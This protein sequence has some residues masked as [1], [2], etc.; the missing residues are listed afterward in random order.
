MPGFISSFSNGEDTVYAANADFT[1]LTNQNPTIANGLQTNGQMW[2][3][4]TALNVGGTHINVGEITSPSGT[5]SIGYSAPNITIDL[6]GGGVGIDSIGV[7]T[8]TSPVVPDGTGLITFNGG[9]V[10]S[11]TNPVRTNGTGANTVTLQVQVAQ[12][13]AATDATKIGLSNFNSAQF[14]VDANGFV[15]TSGTGIPNTITGDSGGALSPTAGNWNILGGP[16]VTTSG[17]GSTLTINSVVFTDTT[18]ATLAVDNGY[19]ATAAGTYTLPAAPAQGEEV[20]VFCDTA[21]AVAV[22]ANTGHKIRIGSSITGNAGSLT[23][24]AIGDTVTLRFRTS[25]ATWMTVSSLGN[26]TVSP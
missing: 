24:T 16:G 8:G 20:I 7:Q 19:F 3:G 17:S 14:T 6:A 2:I 1:T 26:W 22:T 13:L 5:V 4:S 12:A 15:S 25:G 23:S 9:V 10:T 21:G 18:A 11:G